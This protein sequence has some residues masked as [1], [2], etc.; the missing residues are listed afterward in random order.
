M[1][2]LQSNT[3]PQINILSLNRLMYRC[4]SIN[5]INDISLVQMHYFVDTSNQRVIMFMR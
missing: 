1:N 2:E 4:T 5:L 3:V